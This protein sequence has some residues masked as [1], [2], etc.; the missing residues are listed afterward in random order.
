V[1]QQSATNS[2]K[3]HCG[4]HGLLQLLCS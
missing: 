4:R 3:R 1:E 2:Y